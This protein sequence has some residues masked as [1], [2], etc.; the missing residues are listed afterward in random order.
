MAAH[1][2]E[3]QRSMLL[4]TDGIESLNSR[5]G[6][7]AGNLARLLIR[8]GLKF[9]RRHGDGPIFGHLVLF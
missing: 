8:D 5:G 7:V 4:M 6:I 1:V 3:A 9:L 2:D